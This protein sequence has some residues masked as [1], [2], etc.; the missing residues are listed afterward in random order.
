M[1]SPEYIKLTRGDS[2]NLSCSVKYF[3]TTD[4]LA[5]Y[6]DKTLVGGGS[7][8]NQAPVLT[9]T[10]KISSVQV[11]VILEGLGSF[12]LYLKSFIME[13]ETLANLMVYSVINMFFFQTW[14]TGIFKAQ[15]GGSEKE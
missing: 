14:N 9:S 10:L 1:L 12:L 13:M 6:K 8:S 11:G 7:A 15:A 5:W 2:I 4:K 3:S